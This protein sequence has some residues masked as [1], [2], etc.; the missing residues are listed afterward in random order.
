[1]G[2]RL[3]AIPAEAVGAVK[4]HP[5][6]AVVALGAAG[7]LYY[8]YS[9]NKAA[10]QS[11]TTTV[12]P[13]SAYGSYMSYSAPLVYTPNVSA[14]GGADLGTS[15]TVAIGGNV[16]QTDLLNFEKIKEDHSYAL[17]QLTLK[18]QAD[19]AAAN[20]AV[21][22]AGVSSANYQAAS[23]LAQTFMLSGNDLGGGIVQGPGGVNLVYNFANHVYD[24][25]TYGQG[26]TRFENNVRGDSIGSF[27]AN[28]S[29]SLTFINQNQQSAPATTPVTASNTNTNGTTA[30][31]A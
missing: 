5:I 27:L 4:A 23:A 25:S 15:G 30:N 13:N 3:K 26:S 19:I 21:Q 20:A 14:S 6:I 10:A 2:M 29:R 12:D 28:A 1:M 22:L 11:D 17:Q 9:A 18:Q 7:F 16:T 24:N 8:G 31:A